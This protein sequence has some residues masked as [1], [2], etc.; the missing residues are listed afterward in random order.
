MQ[1]K[2]DRELVIKL[3]GEWLSESG[4]LTVH[5]PQSGEQID[6]DDSYALTKAFQETPQNLAWLAALPDK[7]AVIGIT[8]LQ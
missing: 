4:Y 7:T 5:C 3:H 8:Y 2:Y 1:D 6:D